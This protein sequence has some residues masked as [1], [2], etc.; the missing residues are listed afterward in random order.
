MG[1]AKS[2]IKSPT[3]TQPEAI[4]IRGG[5]PKKLSAEEVEKRNM[6]RV[7]GAAPDSFAPA[8]K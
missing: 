7:R 1:N 8:T 3:T 6:P 5:M 2:E 4:K